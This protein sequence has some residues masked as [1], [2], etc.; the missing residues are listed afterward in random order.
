MGGLLEGL[1]IVEIILEGL[2]QINYVF[3]VIIILALIPA[4]IGA[5]RRSIIK[6]AFKF[7][8]YG[9]IFMFAIIYIDR[10][11]DYVGNNFLT[12]IG[13]QVSLTYDGNTVAAT[14]LFELFNTLFE[15]DTSVSPEF[16]DGLTFTVVKNVTWIIIYP[17]LTTISYILTTILWI[18]VTLFMPRALRKKIK[19]LKLKALNLPLA[20]VFS[21]V[22]ALL[23]ISPYVN[24]SS[25]LKD[26]VV[27]PESPISFISASYSGVLAWFTPEKSF[28]LKSLD[29]I[30]IPQLFVFFDTFSVTQGTV[31]TEYN[32]IE[33]L[34]GIINRVGAITPQ[35]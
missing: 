26:V 23:M 2:G 15:H 6:T 18:I 29:V 34:Q 3:D 24:L 7:L 19:S 5:A 33:E 4:L 30:K 28:I 31:V 8:T 10:I 32:F 13:M 12:L 16:I 22:L 14:S 11:T 20:A 27:E 17:L 25:A 35:S 1:N 9:L 21:L